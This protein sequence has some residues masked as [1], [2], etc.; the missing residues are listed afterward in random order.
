[1]KIFNIIVNVIMGL[2]M[3]A[4]GVGHF[5]TPE[6]S[7]GFI[8]DFLPKEIV[9]YSI[10]V[11]ELVLGI[12]LFIPKFRSKAALAVLVL[13]I[14]FMPLHVVDFFR[15]T[16]IIGSKTAAGVRIFMQFVFIYFAWL[17]SKPQTLK[18]FHKG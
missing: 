13:M 1:M 2:L 11:L 16:P 12:L 14:A 10:G 9:H 5:V 18:P 17:V 8:P 3:L 7:S 15:E 4:G 6:A